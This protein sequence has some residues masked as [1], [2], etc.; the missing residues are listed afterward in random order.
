MKYL[1]IMFLLVLPACSLFTKEPPVQVAC[2]P[3]KL[4][5]VH[6]VVQPVTQVPLSWT[7]IE[8]SNKDLKFCL[9]EDDY[10]NNQINNQ[11][12][13]RYMMGQQEVVLFYK[14]LLEK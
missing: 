5:V 1:V 10:K 6:P 13:K 14:K 3:V 11:E 9:K 4:Q 12:I 8:D 7:V 2:K